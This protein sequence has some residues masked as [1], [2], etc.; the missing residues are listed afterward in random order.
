MQLEH[1][2]LEGLEGAEAELQVQHAEGSVE[3]TCRRVFCREFAA[4]QPALG[5]WQAWGWRCKGRIR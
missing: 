3:S 1:V 2:W 5:D 4:G